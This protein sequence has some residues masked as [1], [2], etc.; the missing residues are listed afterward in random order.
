MRPLLL[1]LVILIALPAVAG[2]ATVRVDAYQ[3]PAGIEPESSCSRYMMCPPATL[4]FTAA[5]GEVNDVTITREGILYTVRDSGAPVDAASGCQRVDAQTVTCN[6][7]VVGSVALG[8]GDDRITSVAGGVAGGDGN[9]VMSAGGGDGG[10]GDDIVTCATAGGCNLS[11]GPGLDRVTGGPGHDAINGGPGGP[12][13]DDVLDGGD[14]VDLVSYA[15]HTLP[16]SV[17]LSDP[18]QRFAAAGENDTI[19]RFERVAGGSANDVLGGAE[20]VTMPTAIAGMTGGAGDDQITVRSRMEAHGEQGDDTI[21]GPTDSL[22]GFLGGS[23]DDRLSGAT[24]RDLLDG[25]TGD[26]ELRGGLGNDRLSGGS[27]AD[28][29]LGQQG[30]DTLTGFDRRRGNDRLSCGAGRDRATA[31]RRDRATGCERLRRRR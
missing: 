22:V 10:G 30:D 6:A 7:E 12:G 19:G 4:V 15:T 29:L 5:A 13:D 8:D 18:P 26:D 21:A 9:D 20:G 27:G 24:G 1:A 28:V 31:D 16:V 3:E 11:G 25:G 23:G 17:D 2:A 14:G